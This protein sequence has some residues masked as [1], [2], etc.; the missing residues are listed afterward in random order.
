MDFLQEKGVNFT[1]TEVILKENISRVKSK[2]L[3]NIMRPKS[4]FLKVI[5]IITG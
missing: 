2:A 4:F 5:F 3:A 1:T